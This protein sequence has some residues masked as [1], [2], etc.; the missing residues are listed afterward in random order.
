LQ[1]SYDELASLAQLV[2]Q[3]LR[4]LEHPLVVVLMECELQNLSKLDA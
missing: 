3:Q 4:A 2:L 1:P